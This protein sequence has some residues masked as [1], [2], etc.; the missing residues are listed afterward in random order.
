MGWPDFACLWNSII[1][2]WVACPAKSAAMSMIDGPVICAVLSM[3][4]LPYSRRLHRGPNDIRLTCRTT[5]VKGFTAWVDVEICPVL[6]AMDVSRRFECQPLGRIGH[7]QALAADHHIRMRQ[8]LAE[9]E[10]ELMRVVDRGG[11]R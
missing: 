5:F 2:A 7:A 10:D 6:T 11:R 9:G 4:S 8:R 3:N 1:V